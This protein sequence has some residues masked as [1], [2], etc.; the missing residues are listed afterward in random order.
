MQLVLY[1]NNARN[2][3]AEEGTP[4]VVMSLADVRATATWWIMKTRLHKAKARGC[5]SLHVYYAYFEIT[6]ISGPCIQPFT[7][8]P[9]EWPKYDNFNRLSSHK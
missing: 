8:T 4:F 2:L 1:L 6:N 7:L 5:I 3:G 9:L